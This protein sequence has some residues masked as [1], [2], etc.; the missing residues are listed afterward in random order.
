VLEL[1]F[2]L[3]T[4][5]VCL[6]LILL[7][8]IAWAASWFVLP[9]SRCEKNGD[10]TINACAAVSGGVGA[11]KGSDKIVWALVNPGDIVNFRGAWGPSDCHD[12]AQYCVLVRKSGVVGSPITLDFSSSTL[13]SN[14]LRAKAVETGATRNLVIKNVTATR[15]TTYGI[16][17]NSAGAPSDPLNIT[18]EAPTISHITGCSGECTGIRAKG[19]GVKIHNARV[20]QISDDGIWTDG[21]RVEVYFDVNDGTYFVKDVGLGPKISGDCFQFSGSGNYDSNYLRKGYCD[22]RSVDEKQCVVS[23]S[24]GL[25]TVT[26]TVCLADSAG[27]TIGIYSNG[28]LQLERNFI[29]GWSIGISAATAANAEAGASLIASNIVVDFGTIGI[30][31]GTT[32]PNGTT[33]TLAN[34][35]VDGT[36]SDTSVSQCFNLGGGAG[37][38]VKATNNIAV[39]CRYAFFRAGGTGVKT[40][41]TNLDFGGEFAYYGFNSGSTTSSPR[42]IGGTD[43]IARYQLGPLSPAL[44]TGDCYLASGCAYPDH[45][46]VGQSIPPSIGAFGGW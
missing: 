27:T 5:Y 19:S 8:N 28:R 44:R 23:N 4:R 16:N 18:L 24:R 21:D 1:Q 33:V 40:L 3:I 30:A 39:N 11:W 43:P 12:P 2:R 9:A 25:L 36:N 7:P 15:F 37:S 20:S 29:S 14:F 17:M 13:D 6:A 42:F 26:D 35:T 22:H 38:S 41:S 34:N 45:E 32:I 46:N 31:T 10:G